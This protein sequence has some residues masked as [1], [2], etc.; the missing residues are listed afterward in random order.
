MASSSV[1]HL[2]S[3]PVKS[4]SFTDRVGKSCRLNCNSINAN[5]KKWKQ[6]NRPGGEKSTGTKEV[7]R[8]G[9]AQSLLSW[10]LWSGDVDY[11]PVTLQWGSI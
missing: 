11:A 7:C 8:K 3:L 2:P 4:Q 9:Q 5:V 1:T 6:G 10:W